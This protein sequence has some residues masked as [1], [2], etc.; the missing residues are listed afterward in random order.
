MIRSC[1]LVSRWVSK[2][3]EILKYFEWANFSSRS[4]LSALPEGLEHVETQGSLSHLAL[5]WGAAG[6]GRRTCSSELDSLPDQVNL[7]LA[8]FTQVCCLTPVGMGLW[9]YRSSII[10]PGSQ[11]VHEA[12]PSF[13][14][15]LPLWHVLHSEVTFECLPGH[16]PQTHPKHLKVSHCHRCDLL[17]LA[18]FIFKRGSDSTFETVWYTACVLSSFRCVW[19]FV[20]L[21]TVACQS[22]LSMGFSRQEYWSGLL[23]PPLE[24]LSDPGIESTSLTPAL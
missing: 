3:R 15:F 12:I 11:S 10:W 21:W 9:P 13:M 2:N 4:K 17:T 20:T 24:D 23:C 16:H 6:L 18:S 1:T 8:C 14:S 5:D 22:P 19:L 7:H